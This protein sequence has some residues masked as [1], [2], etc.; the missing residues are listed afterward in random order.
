MSAFAGPSQGAEKITAH[1]NQDDGLFFWPG[2]QM[3]I[4][5]N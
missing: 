2:M 4:Y 1:F 3:F 5:V